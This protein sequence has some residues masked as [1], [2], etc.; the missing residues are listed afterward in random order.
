MR[1]L[2][3]DV[4]GVKVGNATDDRLR[5]GVTAIVFDKPAIA[6]VDVRG[7]APG[8]R[9]TDLLLPERTV[10]R[11]DA[12]ILSGGSAF[13]LDAASGALAALATMGRGFAVGPARVPI[14]PAAILFDLLNGGDKAWGEEPPYRALGR[15]AV[16]A[17][18]EDFTLGT[19]GAGTGCTIADLKGGLGSASAITDDGHVVGAIAAV[20]ALGRVTMGRGPWFWAAPF[21]SGR[22]FGG[23][24]VPPLVTPDMGEIVV[25]GGRLESTTIAV[26]ATSATL[27]KAQ[28]RHL[29]VMAHDGLARAIYP[30]HTVLDG[31]TVFAAST[32]SAPVAVDLGELTRLGAMAANVLARAVARGV[33]EA[34]TD[35][36]GATSVPAYR[37]AW[38]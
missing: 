3:T 38:G 29:A 32:G 26:V 13:G 17:A 30:V 8:T 35:D 33:Y 16:R 20:N 7:G 37:G 2:V 1:N 36:R 25:K 4:P 22:E 24:G 6:S 34:A 28:C 31:D 19:A 10:E 9:E 21:E 27:T 18:G 14:V 11:V 5:S 23:H 15:S 12:I